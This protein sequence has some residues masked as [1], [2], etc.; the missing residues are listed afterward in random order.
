MAEDLRLLTDK[1][2]P[3]LQEEAKEQLA[4]TWYLELL[5]YRQVASVQC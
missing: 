3:D 2:Y 5:H 4:L 1:A